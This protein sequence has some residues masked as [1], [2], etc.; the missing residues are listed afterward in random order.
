MN[1]RAA[2]VYRLYSAD[3]QLLYVGVAVDPDNRLK[4]HRRTKRWFDQVHS[5]RLAWMASESDAYAAEARAIHMEGPRYNGT[6]NDDW[7]EDKAALGHLLCPGVLARMYARRPLAVALQSQ[8]LR[9]S[10]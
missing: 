7:S 1:N 6:H 8:V 4:E 9:R 10:R 2:C 3:E 5:W